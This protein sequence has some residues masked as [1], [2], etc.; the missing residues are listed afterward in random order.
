LELPTAGSVAIDGKELGTHRKGETEIR[1]NSKVVNQVRP[2]VG[3]VF[4]QYNLWP[5]MTVLEN[6]TEAPRRVR[7][8]G[9]AEAETAARDLLKQVGLE[10]R[11][12]DYPMKLSGGQ[13][14]RVAIVRALAMKPAVMLFDEVTSAL[15]PE[16][17]G[18]VLQ[19]M[20]DLARD[21][22]TMVVV[23]HEMDFAREVASRVIFMDEGVIVE[24]GPPEQIFSDP[25]NPRTRRFLRKVLD[26]LHATEGTLANHG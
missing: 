15:D 19:V 9:R 16:L 5:H 21:G 20:Q 14:Q 4:Q 17:V 18:E 2:E 25:R 3:I 13:Q 10:D 11:A 23:T 6:V 8:Q 1:A 26:R 22:M 7:R 12:N 24:E